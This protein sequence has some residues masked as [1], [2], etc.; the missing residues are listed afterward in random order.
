MF[1]QW[2][3]FF[4]R[5]LLDLVLMM[6]L[7]K[8]LQNCIHVTNV[9]LVSESPRPFH[10]N[11]LFQIITAWSIGLFLWLISSVF[12][13][14]TFFITLGFLL[15]VLKSDCCRIPFILWDFFTKLLSPISFLLCFFLTFKISELFFMRSILLAIRL[16][17]FFPVPQFGY[18]YDSNLDQ[19]NFVTAFSY[20]SI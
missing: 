6:K 8:T 15:F 18:L 1:I 19:F 17:L 4:L 2:S 12:W 5:S 13:L 7:L 3:A 14:T 9:F 16:P 10:T 11:K 20:S